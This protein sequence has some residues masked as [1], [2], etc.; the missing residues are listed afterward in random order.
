MKKEKNHPEAD[1]TQG[2]LAH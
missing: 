2:Q 1:Q